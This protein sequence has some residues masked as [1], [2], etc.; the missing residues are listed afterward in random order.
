MNKCHWKRLVEMFWPLEDLTCLCLLWRLETV[1]FVFT[2]KIGYD[3]HISSHHKM[4]ITNISLRNFHKKPWNI[5]LGTANQR[6]QYMSNQNLRTSLDER[7]KFCTSTWPPTED[8]FITIQKTTDTV[9]NI[10]YSTRRHI[11]YRSLKL[12]TKMVLQP[13]SC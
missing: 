2:L 12:S 10:M 4:K 1:L 5:A 9:H 8:T 13:S 6:V 3:L 7:I 11:T